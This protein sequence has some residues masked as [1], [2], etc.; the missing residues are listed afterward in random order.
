[1]N[2][3]VTGHHGIGP[4]RRTR[5]RRDAHPVVRDAARATLVNLFVVA[6]IEASGHTGFVIT[7]QPLHLATLAAAALVVAATTAR[8][9]ASRALHDYLLFGATFVLQVVLVVAWNVA[10]LWVLLHPFR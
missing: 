5:H 1:M 4:L 3:A 2:A 9:Q 10:A 6:A 7:L 8:M